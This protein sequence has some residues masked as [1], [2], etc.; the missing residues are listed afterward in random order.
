M[1]TSSFN[2]SRS[3]AAWRGCLRYL[4][5]GR[6]VEVRGPALE[7]DVE[8]TRRSFAR[9]GLGRDARVGILAG[10]SYEWVVVDLALQRLGALVVACPEHFAADAPR[11]LVD[12]LALDA[13]CVLAREQGPPAD[14]PPALLTI[15]DLAVRRADERHD[16]LPAGRDVPPHWRP[17]TDEYTVVF[18]SG[19]SGRVRGM[20]VNREGTEDTIDTFVHAFD[21]R[22]SDT[23][24]VALPLSNLQQR[25]MVYGALA[26]GCDVAV[27]PPARM[28]HALQRFQPTIVVAPPIFYQL[29][30]DRF[31]G[32]VGDRGVAAACAL[33]AVRRAG[34]ALP[35]AAVRPVA[36]LAHRPLHDALGGRIR[37]MVTG[38]APTPRRV[39]DSLR[40]AGLPLF[41]AY[42]TTETGI[43]ATNALGVERPGTVGRITPGTT[44][45]IADD[46]E[47]LVTKRRLLTRGYV[48]FG[49][50]ESAVVYRTACTVATGDIGALDVDG[51][52][53]LRGRKS[54]VIV[55]ETGHKVHPEDIEQRI[56]SVEGVRW[57]AVFGAGLPYLVAVV[58]V[59]PTLSDAAGSTIARA[60]LAA[61]GT[62]AR[63]EER[64]QRIVI[65]RDVPTTDNGLLTRNQ[66]LV[67][68]AVYRLVEPELRRDGVVA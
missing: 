51:F 45:T 61:S 18:S 68:H 59:D 23:V 26:H 64:V 47:V 11:T 37:V 34:R 57:T 22:A 24:L 40:G 27:V 43:V 63:A 53:T 42:G 3:L 7:R 32:A 6:S 35:P 13:L 65:R 41:E 31:E 58:G 54:D 16:A 14:A 2:P 4:A 62:A 25:L 52:L 17:E 60:A 12:R 28:L 50:D 9:L 15:D 36:R 44:V 49:E 33:A 67:R 48:I 55:T 19:T 66:K 10:N 46:G 20:M 38:M 1:S 8:A 21:V 30:V 39:F 5:D 29:L 56:A